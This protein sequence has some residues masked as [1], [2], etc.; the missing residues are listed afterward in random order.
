MAFLGAHVSAAGRVGNS[1]KNAQDI[2]A[3]AFALFVRPQ[4]TWKARPLSEEDITDF[5]EKLSSG[6][7]D[8]DKVV[9][10]GSY[11][12]NL[13][14][15][16][17]TKRAQSYE[18]FKD[19][20]TR[21]YLLG[22]PFYNIHPG[23]T[24]GACSVKEAANA[25]A[26][27]INRLHEAVPAVSIL[28]ENAAGQ[29]NS[30]GSRFEE[31][32]MIIDNVKDKSRVGIC[33]DT[34]HMFAAGYDIRS[35]KAYKKSMAEFEQV[36]GLSFLKAIHLNDSKG[37]LGCG[38]DRHENIGKGRIGLKGFQNLMNDQ[39]LVKIPMVLET[40]D[41]SPDIYA[42]E[43]CLLKEMALEKK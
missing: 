7:I 13:G 32:K 1:I 18:L 3:N 27:E 36:I 29:G 30:V 43:I 38:K 19:E 37:E 20:A 21:C 34:C 41:L 39:R 22:L 16:D 15:P 2:G 40:P 11:L 26:E 6:G 10:H 28:L 17:E 31:L 42:K 8:P 24:V 4:R 35:E 25:I 33:L 12:I 23:S 9:P 14:N 5:K